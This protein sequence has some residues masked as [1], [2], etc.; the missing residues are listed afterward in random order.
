MRIEI[1]PLSLR[2][3]QPFAIA[4]GV[5]TTRENVLVRIEGGLGEAAAVPYLGETRERIIADLERIDL[6]AACDP[7]ALADLLD[8]LPLG[9]AAAR[10]AVDMALHDA[11][12][13]RLGQPLYRLLGL[14]PERIPPSS[15]TIAIAEPEQMAAAARASTLPVLKLKLGAVG[16]EA[17]IAAVRAATARPLRADANA[18][19]SRQQAARLLPALFDHGVTLIEQPLAAGDLEGLR[20]LSRLPRRPALYADEGIRSTADILAHAGVVDGIVIKLAKCG[21]IRAALRDINLARALGLEVLISCM[22][23]SSLAVTAAAHIAPLCQHVDL[24]G[25]LLIQGD[26]FEGVTYHEGRLI[27]PDRPGLGVIARGQPR[28]NGEG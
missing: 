17:R 20:E 23:E 26:P 6:S 18:G 14:N 5:S 22:I 19:W 1:E 7:L 2:L 4:H 12:G 27:L 21:G 24:D 10:A 28:T 11:F 3:R 9:S 15:F 8:Q 13:R 16:D 25:P